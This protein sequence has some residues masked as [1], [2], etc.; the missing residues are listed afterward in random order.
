MKKGL[1]IVE[2]PTKVKTIKKYLGKEY[3]VRAS[4][5]HVKDLP[6]KRLGVDKA[7]DF[8]PEYEVIR[9]KGKIIK[10][11]KAAAAKVDDIYLAPDPDREGEA[12]AWHVADEIRHTRSGK[13]K[14]FHRVLFHEL[15]RQGIRDAINA[16][17]ELDRA[18]FDSQQAR[19]ILDRLVGYELSPLLWKKVKSGLSAGR[20]QSVAVRIICDREREIQAFR[21]E[22]YWS[23]TARL[24]GGTPPEFETKAYSFDG[25]KV[26]LKK[27]SD[28]DLVVQEIKTAELRV[29]GVRKKER[30]KNPFPPFITSTMQQDAAR[31]FG[32]SAKKTMTLAQRLYEGVEL[33][34]EGPVGLITYMRTDSTRV[35]DEAVADARSFITREFGD[36]YV[37]SRPRHFKK[38]KMAQDA[39]EA[40]RP[41]SVMRTPESVANSLGRDEARLYS[42]IWKRFVASQMSAAVYDQ[43]RI[44]VS[45][46]RCVLRATGQVMK[47]PGFTKVYGESEP[48]KSVDGKK[49]SD[50]LLPGLSEGD[51]L[52]LLDVRSKQHFTK[53][54]PRYSEASLIKT[55]EEKGIGRPSTYA[56]IISTI[57][58]KDYVVME[59]K[60]FRPTEL[61]FI[62]TDLL[63]GHFAEIMDYRFTASLE[64][65][66]DDIEEGTVS[67]TDTLHKFY[68]A[69]AK[70]LA[71]AAEEMKSVKSE[72]VPSGIKCDKC[73]AEMVIKIGRAG[74]FLACSGY[75]ACKNTKDFKK[76]ENGK[77]VIVESERDAGENCEKCGRPMVIKK[78]RYGEFMA[79]SG[80]PECRN[81]KSIPTGVRCPRDGCKGWIVQKSS[82]KGKVFYGCD[83]YPACDFAIWDKPVNEPCPSCGGSFLTERVGQAGVTVKC[84]DKTCGYVK[85]QEKK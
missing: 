82:R 56:S 53:P 61:G 77:V 58:S 31:R 80:Y 78:G 39:H 43:T 75:P 33:G 34:S 70:S 68:R 47:F 46:G 22:E 12:I 35:A 67:W 14:R 16:P 4:V 28:A 84:P 19:R 63:T 66:L 3:D 40:I 9:G 10:E 24:K 23:V 15:T 1:V 55:L 17:V 13:N 72:G 64:K 65:E 54:P 21:P 81:T 74:E 18:K 30:R 6:R 32:F 50:L 83:K 8:K 11:L 27:A 79:C 42:L 69:F 57:Q 73:G 29:A 71:K 25:R 7:R 48:A 20:V 37:P 2:S 76:D 36:K 62:V 5:G 44:D 51:R 85:L 26:E 38:G 52:D 41:T 59:Q 49:K 60:R 45:A